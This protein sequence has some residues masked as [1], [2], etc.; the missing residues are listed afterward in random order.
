MR[1]VRSTDCP[2]Q[3]D[4]LEILDQHVGMVDLAMRCDYLGLL[5]FLVELK[6]W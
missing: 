1:E 3:S 4:Q 5:E 6:D 2:S